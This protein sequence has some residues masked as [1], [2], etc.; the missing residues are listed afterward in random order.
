MSF[1][2][3]SFFS[4]ELDHGSLKI[5]QFSN[6]P[7][8]N[9][10]SSRHI[11]PI[12]LFAQTH[13]VY[14]TEF[15]CSWGTAKRTRPYWSSTTMWPCWTR[16]RLSTISWERKSIIRWGVAVTLIVIISA[17]WHFE[18]I[19]LWLTFYARFMAQNFALNSEIKKLSWHN[20]HE[21]DDSEKNL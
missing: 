17:R 10:F 6:S 13:I 20:L 4:S 19:A 14:R 12:V 18:T 3:I 9:D 21:F 1:F 16:C 2:S 5:Q 11:I 15:S 8:E 7:T